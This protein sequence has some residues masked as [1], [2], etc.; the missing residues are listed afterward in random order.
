MGQLLALAPPGKEICEILDNFKKL[1]GSSFVNFEKLSTDF[2]EK[3]HVRIKFKQG[4]SSCIVSRFNR[5]EL[6]DDHENQDA[7]LASCRFYSNLIT[8]EVFSVD[9]ATGMSID[10]VMDLP[11]AERDPNPL[12]DKVKAHIIGNQLLGEFS[13]VE[14]DDPNQVILL[15]GITE[16]FESNFW[17]IHT[18][19]R[20]RL[21]RNP[22]NSSFSVSGEISTYVHYFEH[23]NFHF[24]LKKLKVHIKDPL[25]S[26]ESVFAKIR[27]KIHKIKLKLNSK[28]VLLDAE[29]DRYG[30]G[31]SD[32]SKTTSAA[33]SSKY[34]SVS[35]IQPVS[36]LKKLRRQLPIHKGKFDWNLARVQLLNNLS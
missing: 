28:F 25:D 35:G 16:S 4:A 19:C 1:L 8:G 9:F 17:S 23:C 12:R 26:L 29:F 14:T 36:I 13:L 34:S 15:N 5:L 31:S 33:S 6:D 27:H 2:A 3:N 24:C 21:G 18:A 11:D 32:G 22:D 10:K 7:N 20:W 30:P